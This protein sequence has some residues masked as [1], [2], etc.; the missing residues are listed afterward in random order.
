MF[1]SS[2]SFLERWN[3]PGRVESRYIFRNAGDVIFH[4]TGKYNQHVCFDF[5]RFTI[6]SL[7]KYKLLI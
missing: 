7:L 5:R 6:C 4:S 3:L 1:Q 2:F